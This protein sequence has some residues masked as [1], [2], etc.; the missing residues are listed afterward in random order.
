[1][2][3]LLAKEHACVAELKK[4]KNVQIISSQDDM[5]EHGIIKIQ[6]KGGDIGE[7]LQTIQD[8]PTI[9]TLLPHIVVDT[10]GSQPYIRIVFVA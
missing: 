4:N 6:A 9:K 5:D 7:L 2:E 10:S 3:K 8:N 1:M